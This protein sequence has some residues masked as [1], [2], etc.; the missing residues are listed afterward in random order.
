MVERTM[1]EFPTQQC[2]GGRAVTGAGDA[3]E[4][5]SPSSGELLAVVHD[6]SAADLDA[7]VDAAQAA[8]R[9]WFKAGPGVRMAALRAMAAR[10]REH[11]DELALIDACDTGNP[12]SGMHFDA[13]LAATLVDY[14]AGIATE[15]KGETIPQKDG[16]LTYVVRE[17]VGVVA[18]LVAF[19][20]PLLFACIKMA[21]PLASGNAVIIKPSEETPLSALRVAQLC[22]DLFPPGVVSVLTGGADLGAAICGHPRIGAVG[23]IGS[24]ATGKAVMRGAAATIKQTQLELGGKNALVIC[25]DADVDAAVAGALKGM[26]FGWTAGQSCGSTSR[27]LVHESLYPAVVAQLTAAFDAIALGDP[28]DPNT[29]MGC[30]S[31]QAQFDKVQGFLARALAAGAQVP[32]RREVDPALSKG[33]YVRPTLVTALSPDMEIAREEVFGPVLSVLSWTE[34]EHMLAMVNGVDVGLTASIWTESLE[35]ALRL[36]DRIQ[37]GYVWVN[38]ASDHYLGAPFGGVKQS[39]L[40]REE[41]L[42]ELLAYTEKK[43]VTLVSRKT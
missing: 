28:L 23:L 2:I 43:T 24:V 31:T 8:Q 4:V 38:D 21:A 27:V 42:D 41:C 11:A 12:V 5:R 3:R 37:A 16:R 1:P 26:N 13:M 35:T 30:L 40:G 19:N 10:I 34:E 39:G 9:A 18:R 25:P 17:P 15:A 20:H 7:A 36:S 22:A 6:A 33:F 14:F 29:E 32:T